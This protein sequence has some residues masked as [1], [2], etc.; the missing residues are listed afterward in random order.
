MLRVR[1]CLSALE[2]AVREGE[3]PS[4]MGVRARVK[5]L[6][7]VEL[8]GNAALNGWVQPAF[9]PVYFPG[10]GQRRFGRPVKGSRNVVP[11]G[12]PYSR[13]CNAASLDRGTRF[14]TDAGIMV[15]TT[16]LETRTK[17]SNIYASVRVSNPYAQ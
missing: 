15:V 16:R 2:R 8:F 9:V 5:L 7:R 13:E 14:G 3:I 12:A 17:E 11:S 10:A 6:R 1:P 4:G